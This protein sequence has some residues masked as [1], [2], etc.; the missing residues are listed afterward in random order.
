M[1]GSLPAA[2]EEH[3]DDANE[4]PDALL[5]YAAFAGIIGTRLGQLHV[6]LA[7]PSDD[8]AF[9]PEHATPEHVDGWCADAIA[10]FE[11]ALDVLHTRL[12]ALDPRCARRPTRCSRHATRPCAR[13]A[14]SCRARSMR[15]RIHGDFHLAGSTCRATRC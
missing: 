13:S 3:T 4:E 1:D 10:S 2:D 11:H 6:A 7:Q 5:G 8:P 15:M 12:D 9:A 14:S